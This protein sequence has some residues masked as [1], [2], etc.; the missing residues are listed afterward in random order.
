MHGAITSK[1][2]EGTSDLVVVAPIKQGFI[3]TMDAVTYESRLRMIAKALFKA[4]ATV[5]EHALIR[6]FTDPV[7]RIQSLFDFRVAIIGNAPTKSLVLAATFDRPF[8]PYMRLIWRPLGPF[9]DAFFCNCEGYVSAVDHDFP[10]FLA[11]VRR[12]Q[13]DSNF[14]YSTSAASV[15]DIRYLSQIEELHREGRRPNAEFVATGIS[16]ADLEAPAARCRTA[17]QSRAAADELALE[18]LGSIYRLTSVYPPDQMDLHGKYLLRATR[19]LLSDWQTHALPDALRNRFHEQLQWFE[20]DPDA[21]RAPL[22]AKLPNALPDSAR[23]NMQGGILES[24]NR[25]ERPMTHGALLLVSVDSAA[26]GREFLNWLNTH[27]RNAAA[28]ADPANG[29]YVNVSVTAGGLASL[30]V[31]DTDIAKFPAEYREGMVDRAGQLG[32]FRGSHPRRWRLPERNWP[33][34]PASGSRVDRA[35]VDPAEIDMLVQL[36]TGSDS[37]TYDVVTHLDHPL[38]AF[39]EEF[40]HVAGRH[41]VRLLSVESMRRIKSPRAATGTAERGGHFG[42]VDDLSQPQVDPKLSDWTDR[43]ALGELM[44]GYANDRG[45]PAPPAD[46]LLNDGSFL[47]VRKLQQDVAGLNRFLNVAGDATPG[48]GGDEL[49]ARMVGRQADGT[50]LV[51]GVAPDSNNFDFADDPE[52]R[53]CPLQAHIRRANPRTPP[54]FGRQVPRIARRGMSWGS[55]ISEAPDSDR[56][57]LMFMAYNSSIAEQFEVIQRWIN[58]GNPTG[59]ASCQNDPLMGFADADTPRTFAFSFQGRVV[60][61]ELPKP[62]V[63]L[64]WGAYFFT[65]SIAALKLLATPLSKLPT[66]TPSPAAARGETTIKRIA[67]LANH[68]QGLEWKRCL[69]DFSAKDP[70]E[71]DEASCV[72]AAVRELHAGALRIHYGK[73]NEPVTLAASAS[74]VNEVFANADDTYTV[75]GMADRMKQSFGM[76]YLGRDAGSNYQAEAAAT[77]A[78][79]M[80]ETQ[81]DAFAGGRK[82]GDA[83]LDMIFANFEMVTGNR[84]GSFD[85]H[86]EYI[87]PVLAELCRAWFGLPNDRTS[88]PGVDPTIVTGGWSWE[89]NHKPRCPGDFMAPSRYCFYPDPSPATAAFGQIQGAALHEGAKLHFEAYRNRNLLPPGSFAQAMNDAIADVDQLARTVVGVMVGMLP[90]TDGNL[91]AALYEWTEQRTLWRIQ[92]ALIAN[93]EKDAFD[94]AQVA[95]VPALMGSMQVRPAPDL[96]WRTATIKHNLGNCVVEKGERVIIG[97]AGATLELREEGE[98]NVFPVFGGARQGAVQPKPLHA[99]PAYNMAIGSMLGV[100]SALLERGRIETLPSPLIVKLTE[101]QRR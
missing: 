53:R 24:Y 58:G 2:L 49:L 17:R 69:E 68:L 73:S 80:A 72:W 99:C 42:L 48:L 79:L 61:V 14:F 100:L 75:E 59:V 46:P 10:T 31:A 54:K 64:E 74:L 65:P 3:D 62:V 23:A 89:P 66:S 87:T 37:G 13:A 43:V 52:G 30:G 51:D 15:T 81:R 90:P 83:V 76:I 98:L 26:G 41:Q 97:V 18:G 20:T 39:V 88:P 82:A 21:Y 63:Q 33:P 95:L 101:F 38:R 70:G 35:P 4:R 50:P 45:D 40:G 86:R 7:E 27:V 25:P 91:R 44:L 11:W 32:D 93:G 6:P 71:S 34:L 5:R 1:H 19:D 78:I 94:R 12:A 57:G 9:L 92:Q 84:E 28:T 16:A 67:G 36:R 47:V 22:Q 8:E 96:L 60:R 85:L 56:R 29:V 55:T 77:N